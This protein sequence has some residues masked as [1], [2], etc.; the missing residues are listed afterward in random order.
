VLLS[1]ELTFLSNWSLYVLM[2]FPIVCF[3]APPENLVLLLNFFVSSFVVKGI[4]CKK[5]VANKRMPSK[6]EKP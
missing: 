5:N 3:C 2:S 4:V 1:V 6:K